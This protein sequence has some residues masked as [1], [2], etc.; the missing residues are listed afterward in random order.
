MEMLEPY[1]TW[2][3]AQVA[4][5]L[6]PLVDVD[7]F[8]SFIENNVDGSLLPFLTTDHLRELGILNLN[9]RLRVKQAIKNLI[10]EL[11]SGD[12]AP[13]LADLGR[14]KN[15]NIDSNYVSIEAMNL[16]LKL[17]QSLPQPATTKD[18]K[19]LEDHF[20]K[21]KADLGPVV[22]LA[23]EVKPLPVPTLDPGHLKSLPTL[24]AG[25]N[26]SV[27]ALPSPDHESDSGASTLNLALPNLLHRQP[28]IN[29][30]H[31]YL[32]N[33]NMPKLQRAQSG[34]SYSQALPSPS[35]SN[36]WSTASVLSTGVGKITDMK[37]NAPSRVTPKLR[38]VDSAQGDSNPTSPN[39]LHTV[40]FR[41]PLRSKQSSA[42]LATSHSTSGQKDV[43][44]L[45]AFKASSEDTG[46][47][48]L[49]SAIRKNNIPKENWSK[50]ALV[51]CYDDKERIVKL[52][53]KP[54]SIF[55]DL[56]EQ[57]KNPTIMLREL[58]LSA[59]D[60]N[61]EDSGEEAIPGGML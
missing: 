51:I 35:Q 18:V 25:S 58:N 44:P 61:A 54:V 19:K 43:Q 49:Q 28:S 21:L 16:C 60:P 30:R 37:Q 59:E 41:Q 53:E 46:L 47:R 14:M 2:D 40:T 33:S 8:D 7:I 39:G 56:Q 22:R 29:E 17:L 36:R 6:L 13:K 4:L 48:L 42:L 20:R 23:N 34:S 27:S 5:Y 38:L 1:L 15:L 11:Y 32:D 24:T 52:T 10:H 50:Y 3:P 31:E 26:G 57:G 9:Q 12:G 45:Q 55:K